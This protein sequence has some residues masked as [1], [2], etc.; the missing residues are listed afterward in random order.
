MAAG[1]RHIG[2]SKRMNLARQHCKK[3]R[4]IPQEPCKKGMTT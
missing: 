2:A 4:K 3:I 1:Q